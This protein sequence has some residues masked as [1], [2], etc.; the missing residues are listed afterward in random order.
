[1]AAEDLMVAEDLT[2]AA[3]GTGNRSYVVSLLV[4][5]TLKWREAICGERS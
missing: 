2:E 5:K 4:C 1:M 3:V